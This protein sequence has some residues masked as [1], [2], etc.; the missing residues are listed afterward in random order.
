MNRSASPSLRTSPANESLAKLHFHQGAHVALASEEDKFQS[1]R[2]RR[3]C[4]QRWPTCQVCSARSVHVASP[5]L[6]LSPVLRSS[7]SIV[8]L[9]ISLCHRFLEMW[10]SPISF[11]RGSIGELCSPL[12]ASGTPNSRISIKTGILTKLGYIHKSWLR[13]YFVLTPTELQYYTREGGTL[14]GSIALR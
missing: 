13:R 2:S 8:V 1:S 4:R 7:A 14:R 9:S 12:L 5:F 3:S 10:L 6:A 11:P